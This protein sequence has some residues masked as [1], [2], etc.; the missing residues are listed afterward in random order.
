[1]IARATALLS[2][3]ALLAVAQTVVPGETCRTA[4]SWATNLA[5]PFAL[6]SLWRDLSSATSDGRSA[7]ATAA[8][9]RIA[10]LVPSWTDGT[11]LVAWLMAFDEASDAPT[12]DAAAERVLAAIAW[13]EDRAGERAV[14][15]PAQAADLLGTAATIAES[16]FGRLPEATAVLRDQQG[17][18]PSALAAGLLGRAADLDPSAARSERRALATLRAACAAIRFGDFARGAIA[19]EAARAQFSAA[20]TDFAQDAAKAL[21]ELPTLSQL[22]ANSSPLRTQSAHPLLLDLA[23]ALDALRA[24]VA[25]R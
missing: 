7:D 24:A 23:D 13:L 12:P 9:S 11:A 5:R 15:A 19:L 3:G 4:A 10:T 8:A 21:R 6:P 18:E 17:L 2:A 16:A 14:M 25:D 20:D 22:A 1:M